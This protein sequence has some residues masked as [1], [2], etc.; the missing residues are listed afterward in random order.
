MPMLIPRVLL[1]AGLLVSLFGSVAEAQ[2]VHRLGN[3]PLNSNPGRTFFQAPDGFLYGVLRET[4]LPVN[5]QEEYLIESGIKRPSKMGAVYR[6]STTGTLSYIHQFPYLYNVPGFDPVGGWPTDQLAL[7]PDGN[8]YGLTISGGTM[9][10]GVFYRLQPDGTYTVLTHLDLSRWQFAYMSSGLI[11]G[12]DDAFY[13]FYNQ[14]SGPKS[15]VRL[16]LD[17]QISQV[18][19]A[20]DSYRTLWPGPQAGTVTVVGGTNTSTP[21][22]TQYSVVMDTVEIPSG[23]RLSHREFSPFAAGSDSPQLV[24]VRGSEVLLYT[25]YVGSVYGNGRLVSIDPEGT[26]TTVA[27]FAHSYDDPTGLPPTAFSLWVA[28][29]GDIYFTSGPQ[30]H[31]LTSVGTGSRLYRLYRDGTYQLVSD[32]GGYP[33]AAITEGLDGTIYGVSWGPQIEA[34]E[35]QAAASVSEN[36]HASRSVKASRTLPGRVRHGAF[37]VLPV[38]STQANLLPLA[39]RDSGILRAP[40]KGG[41]AQATI[42]VLRNDRD[43]ERT[44]LELVDVGTPQHGQVTVQT[45]RRG[46]PLVTYT[47]SVTPSASE[48]ITYRVKD[49]AGGISTGQIG[50]RGEVEGSFIS[51]PASEDQPV[52]RIRISRAGAVTASVSQGELRVPLSGKL[53]YTDTARLSRRTRQGKVVALEFTLGRTPNSERSLDYKVTT[54]AGEFTGTLV[55]K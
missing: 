32:F 6:L 46:Q 8:L 33:V 50:I 36:A 43:P 24:A 19:E 51:T 11:P 4:Y 28:S 12:P 1:A 40:K 55:K 16:G 31:G 14:D 38:G 37:R 7:G 20:F 3:L 30:E 25:P 18:G 2:T 34:E 5:L 41:P 49:E 48:Q 44:A 13:V 9:G 21:S 35:P 15:V 22:G 39:K 17:G 47:S 26:V 54:E 53:D 27:E 29:N 52:V 42:P 45:D 23:N 10:N